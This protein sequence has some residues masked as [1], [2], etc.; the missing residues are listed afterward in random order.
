M[1]KVG[2]EK[3]S[4]ENAHRRVLSE[5]VIS[6]LNSPPFEKSAMDGYAIHAEDTF[7]F[8]ETNPATLKIIN[9][10][11]AGQ[12]S[13]KLVE[14]GEAVRIATGAPIPERAN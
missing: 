14:H 1:K 10:I 6:E 3:I 11:G 2:V 13:S 9:T 12:V 5:E 8:S 4:L 7:E